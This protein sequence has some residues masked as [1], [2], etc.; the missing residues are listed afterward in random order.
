MAG[1][2]PGFEIS[3][4]GL[5]AQ[6]LRMDLASANLANAQTTNGP[7]GGPWKKLSPVFEARSLEFDNA[8][9]DVEA[10]LKR[11][12]VTGVE[13]DRTNP[14]LVYDPTHPDADAKG[15]VAMPN[16]NMMEEMAD[17]LMASRSYEANVTAF[18]MSKSMA[19]S[20]LNLG[21]I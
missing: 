6:R 17:L 3:A 20:A 15:F 4:S 14:R 19:M 16:V 8:L 11:V 13:K 7:D 1:I 10:Q 2:F 9:N 12:D 21:K 18:N 5:E